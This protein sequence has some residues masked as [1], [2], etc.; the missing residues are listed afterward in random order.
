MSIRKPTNDTESVDLD[1][2]GSNEEQAETRTI[3]SR[4]RLRSKMQDEIDAFLSAGGEINK[5]A[6]NVC[7]DPPAKPT[8]HYGSRPI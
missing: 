6:P 5:I 4:Q 8:S 1:F 7:A 3:A 2:V